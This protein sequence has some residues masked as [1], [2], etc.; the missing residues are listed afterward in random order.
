M[1]PSVLQQLK[2]LFD[3]SQWILL[4]KTE[5]VREEIIMIV[6]VDTNLARNENS[7]SELLG[8]RKQLQA[9]AASNELYIPEVVID[10]IVTQKRLSFLREQAQIN[11]SGILK[12]TSFSI[13]EAESLAFEQVEKKIRSD[14]SIPFNVLPQAP[15]EYA[16]SRIYNWAINHEPPFEEK[17][18]KGFKDACIV[19]SIDFFLEQ[20]SEEKQVLICTDDKRMAEY[21]KDRTNI[22]VEED[23]KNVIKLNNRPK[24][25]ESVE[26]TTNT[27]DFDT[28]NAANADVNDLIEELA[29][30]LSFA[31][32][33][34]IISKLSS[35]P[36]VT[37][38]Q[39]ELRI[40]SVALENQQVEWI[41]KDD[42]VSEYIKPI[43]LRHKEELIDNEYTRYLDA[44]DLPDERE[45]KRE[46]PFFT[47]KEKRAFCDFINE[48]ISHTV[49]KS[50]LSTFEINA[51]TI[52]ARL[53]SLLKSHLLDSSLA[54]VKYLTDI[55]IN[56][57]VETKPGSISI[58]TISDFVNLLDN[59]SPRKREA[60]MANLISRL[61]DIDDDISF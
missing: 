44:F 41:L 49:C 12:L 42:D 6:I 37:S 24:V 54:N 39:Q 22:T 28:K 46:S 1:A 11:R 32:T 8:N 30:S 19:A 31:E 48:I 40:L 47:T 17:S 56:G 61:E 4:F 2:T 14:K 53:Q 7:Y 5:T 38:D 43:F 20:S 55:L 13:D 21:F 36:H 59:A 10:E 34:S 50:H 23:L 45:E 25:K 15:V 3:A 9:I 27:S 51:N 26:T 60:I 16:F 52:L 35:S 33:H 57:A 29:N 18:D 58:D